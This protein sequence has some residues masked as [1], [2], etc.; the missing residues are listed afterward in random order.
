[1][2]KTV[3][4]IG[5]IVY[6]E[7]SQGETCFPTD[8]TQINS[9]NS[10]STYSNSSLLFSEYYMVLDCNYDEKG[11]SNEMVRI[12]SLPDY[13]HYDKGILTDCEVY[14]DINSLI[15]MFNSRYKDIHLEEVN[16]ICLIP[17]SR[18]IIYIYAIDLDSND[19][20]VTDD[21]KIKDAPKVTESTRLWLRTLHGDFEPKGN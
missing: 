8:I 13:Y 10:F 19:L 17:E 2:R 21:L 5:S 18:R 15:W 3:K 11:F 12:S 7:W 20:N 1:M 6:P 9:V 14:I 16:Y 4:D